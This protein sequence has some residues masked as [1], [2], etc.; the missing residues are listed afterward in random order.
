M[1][2]L[3]AR[4]SAAALRL[5]AEAEAARRPATAARVW[6]GQENP[7]FRA[8]I[9]E[10]ERSAEHPGN[11]YLQRNPASGALGRYQFVPV[12]LQDIG[13]RDAEGGWTALAERHGVTSEEE[14]LASPAAQEAAMTAYLR[15]Q[16]VLLERVGAMGAA[17]RSLPA[18]E[19]GEVPVTPSGLVAAAHRRG[20][21]AVARY[22]AHRST[23]PEAPVPPEQ[24]QAF[25]QV[26]RRLRDF[27]EVQY[28]PA[29][30]ATV[31]VAVR[32]PGRRGVS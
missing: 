4:E 24:R 18:L 10:A 14:F 8:R 31:A 11:G 15:R 21:G 19:G 25:T 30:S 28:G 22:V 2:T 29:A 5:Q 32:P 6:E 7:G 13:W 26:E 1:P 23:T 20:A 17:G 9:A 16:E 3:R 12:A 27:A